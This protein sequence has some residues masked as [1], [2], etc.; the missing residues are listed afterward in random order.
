MWV[1]WLHVCLGIMC[2]AS[3]EV[4]SPLTFLSHPQIQR[5]VTVAGTNS[6]VTA[7]GTLPIGV[8]GRMQRET[9]GAGLAT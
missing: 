4:T 7:T 5:A 3:W 9:A 6:R 1:L 2:V 8:P